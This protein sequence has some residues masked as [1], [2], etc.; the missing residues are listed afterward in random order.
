MG[1]TGII[2]FKLFQIRFVLYFFF[3][4]FLLLFVFII[5]CVLT[6]RPLWSKQLNY[7]WLKKALVQYFK[8]AD[9]THTPSK[10]EGKVQRQLTALMD[11]KTTE[12]RML[13]FGKLF[14][15]ELRPVSTD[16]IKRASTAKVVAFPFHYYL[17]T[18]TFMRIN[19]TSCCCL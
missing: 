15:D 14:K 6:T 12:S 3:F 1:G 10:C 4:S 2:Y 7:Q 13:R 19:W 5:S 18:D 17:C 9:D 16:V 8:Y 11:A